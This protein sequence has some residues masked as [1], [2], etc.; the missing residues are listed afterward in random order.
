MKKVVIAGGSG[1][2]GDA[3]T[4]LFAKKGYEVVILSRSGRAPSGARGVTWDARHGGDWTRELAGAAGVINLVGAPIAQKWTKAAKDE[5]LASRVLS[6]EAIGAALEETADRP[7]VWINGSAVG[8]YGNRGDT[9]LTEDADPGPKGNFMVDTVVAWEATMDGYDIPGL[10]RVKMRTG[11]PLGLKGGIFPPFLT[12]TKFFLGGHHGSGDQFYSWIHVD[13]LAQI[14]LFAL[15]GKVEGVVNGTAPNPVSDRYLMAALRGVVGRPWSPPVPAF[16]L[17][18]A[19]WLG[20]PDPSLVLEGQKVLPEKL[21]K[22]GF[23]FQFPELREALVDLVKKDRKQLTA[24]R[25][26]LP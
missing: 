12:L 5:I 7:P 10:R 17:D 14:F 19:N 2:I 26:S 21:V 24:P 25:A 6:T 15:E 9:E 11:L 8:Y 18:F 20:A 22:A 13:D 23:N 16:A 4:D 3:L 1:F